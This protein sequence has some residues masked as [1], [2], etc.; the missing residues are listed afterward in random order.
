MTAHR[1]AAWQ[2]L[3]DDLRAARPEIEAAAVLSPQG[4]AHV[5]SVRP[6][7][8]VDVDRLGALSAAM[9]ALADR[10]AQALARGELEQAMIKGDAGYVLMTHAGP[11]AVLTVLCAPEAPLGMVFHDVRFTARSIVEG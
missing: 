2:T 9:L 5:S 4:L 3:I 7:L 10:T 6:G 8:D 1:H 11:D